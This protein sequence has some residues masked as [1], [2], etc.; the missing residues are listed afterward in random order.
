MDSG[1][2]VEYQGK[3]YRYEKPKRAIEI[4]KDLNL[5]PLE[6]LVIVDGEIYTEDRVVKEGSKAVIKKVTSAG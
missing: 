5:N 6:H 3:S 2:L 4:L 1:I